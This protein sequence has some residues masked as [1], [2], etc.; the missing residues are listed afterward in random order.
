MS[1]E[2]GRHELQLHPRRE[3]KRA[4]REAKGRRS[5]HYE[6]RQRDRREGAKLRGREVGKQRAA[7]LGR[8]RESEGSTGKQTRREAQDWNGGRRQARK[9]QQQQPRKRCV[10][11]RGSGSSVSIAGPDAS[12]RGGE[13]GSTSS[14]SG[15]GRRKRLRAWPDDVGTTCTDVGRGGGSSNGSETNGD[16][17]VVPGTAV[18]CRRRGRD[19]AGETRGR[20]SDD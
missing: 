5:E 14:G 1:K 15:V 16:G 12:R 13:G 17:G 8:E 6:R 2:L 11:S 3:C 19:G 10:G 20:R 7:R 9:Q 4:E 18:D